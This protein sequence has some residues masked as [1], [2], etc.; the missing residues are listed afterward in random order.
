MRVGAEEGINKIVYGLKRLS[1]YSVETEGGKL[2]I[3]PPLDCRACSLLNV[4][5]EELEYPC[6]ALTEKCEGKDWEECNHDRLEEKPCC[7]EC[8]H[9]TDCIKMLKEGYGDELF[10]SLFGCDA[11]TFIKAVEMLAGGT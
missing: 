10:I 1:P 11:E 4:V 2:L 5:C 3:K 8:R 7:W 6:R 9:L